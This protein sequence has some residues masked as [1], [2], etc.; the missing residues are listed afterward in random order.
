MFQY[1]KVKSKLQ[2]LVYPGLELPGN[3][4]VCTI[5]NAGRAGQLAA[6]HKAQDYNA[7]INYNERRL[8]MNSALK[9][10]EGGFSTPTPPPPPPPSHITLTRTFWASERL[11]R[12]ES[13]R[14]NP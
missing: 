6:R 12:G 14:K 2:S 11:V 9:E 5:T 8:I 1:F 4:S 13:S 10:G 7:E 3:E